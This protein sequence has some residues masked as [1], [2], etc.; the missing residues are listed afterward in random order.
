MLK[1]NIP[2]NGLSGI[3]RLSEIFKVAGINLVSVYLNCFDL[4][5]LSNKQII[6]TPHPRRNIKWGS[7]P[8]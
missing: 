6:A 5:G 7:Q 2:N 8:G 4:R 1:Q 3:K